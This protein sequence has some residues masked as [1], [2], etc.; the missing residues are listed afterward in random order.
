MTPTKY[1]ELTWKKEY[2]VGIKEIDK[3]HQKLF[4]IIISLIKASKTN[5]DSEFI[6]VILTELIDYTQYHFS[7]EEELFK[8]LPIEEHHKKEHIKFIESIMQL[9]ASFFREEADIDQR[10]LNFL[11][12]WLREHILDLDQKT[13]SLYKEEKIRR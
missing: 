12:K 1:S 6:K 4:N 7:T 10:L 2:E 8:G 5:I 11:I 13:F 3:Q 9:N